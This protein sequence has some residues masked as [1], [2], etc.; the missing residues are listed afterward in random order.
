LCRTKDVINLPK[1]EDQIR[2]LDFSPKEQEHYD[3]VKNSTIQMMDEAL[4]HNPLAPSQYL[5]ALQWL[6]ELRLI[7]NH[8]L[9]HSRKAP[10]T[11]A[12]TTGIAPNKPWN[13]KIAE[14]AFET[15]VKAGQAVCRL[16]G[17]NITEGT[18]EASNSEF[19]K[20]S[21]SKCLTI[22]CGS[23]IQNGKG[24]QKVPT[25]SCARRCPKVDVS[26][27]PE[28]SVDT[29][30]EKALPII[31][32]GEVST[33]L[34]ALLESLQQSASGEKRYVLTPGVQS[35]ADQVLKLSFH[36]VVFSYWT[37]TLDL[38]EVLL[39]EASIP[40]TRIDGKHSGDQRDEAVHRL[41]TDDTIRVILVSITCGGTGYVSPGLSLNRNC[42]YG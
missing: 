19:P 27:A 8:G 5:N 9:T 22:I 30:S 28:S 17:E 36:S 15:L 40:F 25:C 23:C 3:R 21:L 35:Y 16:C 4:A 29:R 41:E 2:Y 12:T 38:I 6:N 10:D 1:R 31:K 7:C 26:W 18:G 11:I 42:W 13:H 34:R 33:K 14:K 39:K 32:A 37:F 20:P 24:G